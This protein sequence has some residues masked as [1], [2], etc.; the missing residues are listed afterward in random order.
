MQEEREE[1]EWQQVNTNVLIIILLLYQDRYEL[2]TFF[3]QLSIKHICIPSQCFN[4]V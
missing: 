1:V 4:S 2:T 3:T